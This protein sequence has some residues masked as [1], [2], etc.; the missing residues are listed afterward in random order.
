MEWPERLGDAL[1]AARLD[2]RIDGTGDEPRSI[3]LVAGSDEYRRY[4]D[5]AA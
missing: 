1:P 3:T 5:V 4:L 2:V